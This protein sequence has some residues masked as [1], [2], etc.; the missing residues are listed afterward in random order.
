M[1]N[2]L[3]NIGN[4]GVTYRKHGLA[5]NTNGNNVISYKGHRIDVGRSGTITVD[6]N[7]Y[8]IGNGAGGFVNTPKGIINKNKV[9]IGNLCF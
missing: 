2:S 3:Y 1:I 6:S 5:L 4:R 8:S 9:C 7:G